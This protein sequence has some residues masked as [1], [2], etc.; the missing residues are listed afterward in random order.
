MKLE[1]LP[2]ISRIL[3]L[4]LEWRK[5]LELH[6]PD[7]SIVKVKGEGETLEA[8]SPLVHGS[9]PWAFQSIDNNSFVSLAMDLIPCSEGEGFINPSP[10]E[11]EVIDGGKLARKAP[12]EVGEGQVKEPDPN[13]QKIRNLNLFN[14][15][16]HYLNPLYISS[17]GPSSSLSLTTS[18]ISIEG[19]SNSLTLVSNRPFNFSF[20]SGEIELEENVQIYREG[21]RN[22]TKPHRLAWNLVNPIIPI[23]CKPKYRVSLIKIE[24]SSVVPLYLDYRSSTLTLG[25]LNLESR[26]VVATIYLAGRLLST[27]VVDPRDGHVDKLEPEF[28][29]V[30]VPVRRWGLLLLK[31]EIRKLLEGL[32]KKK[33]L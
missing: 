9:F 31:I 25:I 7:E 3:N 26:P 28:D 15:K 19:I 5:N 33:S 12:G 10:W 11:R 14:A 16:F 24:P 13:F 30:K 2:L 18:M 8:S 32:L 22:E 23:D 27:Q 17:V 29:R 20:N 6:G 21:L 4:S 1:Q